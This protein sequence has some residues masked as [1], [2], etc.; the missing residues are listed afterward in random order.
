MLCKVFQIK[1]VPL[2]QNAKSN[3]KKMLNSDI[4]LHRVVDQDP[5][6]HFKV[7]IG[8]Q[9]KD[10]YLGPTRPPTVIQSGEA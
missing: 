10:S 7:V 6:S 8:L 1:I 2:E 9:W 4:Y 3:K 5:Q